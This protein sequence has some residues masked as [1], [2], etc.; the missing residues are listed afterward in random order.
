MIVKSSMTKLDKEND[1]SDQH[2]TKAAS[3]KRAK[4][5]KGISEEN[6]IIKKS[7]NA[8]FK[9]DSKKLK[10]DS[11]HA[12]VSTLTAFVNKLKPGTTAD[13]LMSFV[14][15]HGFQVVS[16]RKIVRSS[17]GFV[18]F[19]SKVELERAVRSLSG[20]LFQDSPVVVALAKSNDTPPAKQ[21]TT[22]QKN[23]N[24]SKRK[25]KEKADRE[26]KTLFV[27]NIGQSVTKEILDQNFP[28]AIKIII[29]KKKDGA[30]KGYALVVY[31]NVDSKDAALIKSQ[32]ITVEGRK[33]FLDSSQSRGEA[34]ATGEKNKVEKKSN[35][36]LVKT[37]QHQ[38]NKL[39]N[40]ALNTDKKEK[41]KIIKKKKEKN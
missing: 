1:I 35:K 30:I 32:G 18:Q 27:K 38:Q 10:F 28:D 4:K 12:D 17:F 31:S 11:D 7:R 16:C 26:S 33:L 14:E 15:S 34:A 23:S 8:S 22:K 19:E 36:T 3:V 40:R 21:D 37:K 25:L 29:P 39:K 5:R 9:N 20:Q 41:T 13:M 2:L 6:P 24:I